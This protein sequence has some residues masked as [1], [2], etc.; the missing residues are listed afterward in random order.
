MV[1]SATL[2]PLLLLV[3]ALSTPRTGCSLLPTAG[4]Q[5]PEAPRSSRGGDGD[6]LLRASRPEQR[7]GGVVSVRLWWRP[8]EPPPAGRGAFL[9]TWEVAGGALRGNLVTD[10][11]CATLS[12]QPATV[13]RIQVSVLHGASASSSRPLVVDTGRALQLRMH[14]QPEAGAAGDGL[15]PGAVQ[16]SPSA[17]RGPKRADPWPTGS[18]LCEQIAASAA[19]E[20]LP[21]QVRSSAPETDLEDGP[22]PTTLPAAATASRDQ[23]SASGVS[24]LPVVELN[25]SSD[26]L[27]TL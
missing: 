23:P 22:G 7:R 20:A 4:R 18:D 19:P 9:V 24:W 27:N 26:W 25:M 12:L 15:W 10:A 16:L 21:L 14:H 1:T 13:F 8:P 6:W 17:C 11:L 2:P 5:D 3:L